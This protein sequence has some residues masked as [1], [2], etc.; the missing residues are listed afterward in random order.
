MD[1]FIVAGSDEGRLKYIPAMQK[2]ML[3]ILEDVLSASVSGTYL[4]R[5]KTRSADR[6]T[7]PAVVEAH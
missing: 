2:A 5:H 7:Y 3:L 1:D 4:G 6:L